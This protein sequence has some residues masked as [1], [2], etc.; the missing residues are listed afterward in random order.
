MKNMLIDT[1]TNVSVEIEKWLSLHKGEFDEYH[2]K[3]R[4]HCYMVDRDGNRYEVFVIVKRIIEDDF[5]AE[6]R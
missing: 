6:D 1:D 3:S 4:H 5:T 2:R